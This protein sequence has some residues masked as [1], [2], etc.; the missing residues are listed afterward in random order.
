MDPRSTCAALIVDESMFGNTRAVSEA[1]ALGLRSRFDDVRIAT[2]E[3]APRSLTDL[4]LLVV[5]APTHAMGLPRPSTRRAASRDGAGD[6]G[7]VG[8]REWL[9]AVLAPTPALPAV[10]F[11]TR[12]ATRLPGTARRPIARRLR[13]RGFDVLGSRSFVVEGAH[14]PLAP[15]ALASARSWGESL[16]AQLIAARAA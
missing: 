3:E 7:P 6:V 1:I 8:V 10:A 12:L 15:D 13:R 2:A 16:A 4:D 11:D 5:G 14:G 9:A